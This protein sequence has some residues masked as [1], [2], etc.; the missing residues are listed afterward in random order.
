MNETYKKSLQTLIKNLKTN[1][2][3]LEND[4]LMSDIEVN[5][6]YHGKIDAFKETIQALNRI[7]RYHNK[8]EPT[9]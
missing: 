6:Q 5:L 2:K 9:P 1:I 4:N 3:T 8:Q 7:I